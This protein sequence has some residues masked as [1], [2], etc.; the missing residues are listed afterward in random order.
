LGRLAPANERKEMSVGTM[1]SATNL[2]VIRIEVLGDA[3]AVTAPGSVWIDW[4]DKAAPLCVDWKQEIRDFCSDRENHR[5][6][7]KEWKSYRGHGITLYLCGGFWVGYYD[8][9]E[10]LWNEAEDDL[11]MFHSNVRSDGPARTEI[12]PLHVST[13]AEHLASKIIPVQLMDGGNIEEVSE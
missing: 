4:K 3:R 13:W 1:V 8:D 11:P 7:H 12:H 2:D 6:S 10:L 9:A 5:I